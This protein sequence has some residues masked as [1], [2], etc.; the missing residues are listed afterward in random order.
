[1]KSIACESRLRSRPTVDQLA[2]PVYTQQ[3]RTVIE[4]Q[5]AVR[6]AATICP[7]PLQVDGHVTLDT[8]FK[9][10]TSKV[11][12][13]RSLILGGQHGHTVMVTYPYAY[14]TYIVSPFA[15]LGGGIS[16]RPPTYI[17]YLH[18]VCFSGDHSR[19]CR[20]P[21]GLRKKNYLDC[22]DQNFTSHRCRVPVSQPTVE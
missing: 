14:M 20:V 10:K 9:I 4:H 15:G 8:T 17:P 1:M 19:L 11:K 22:R 2:T 16:W 6:E 13:T 3:Q 5:Q 12:V 18:L 7:R 21:E